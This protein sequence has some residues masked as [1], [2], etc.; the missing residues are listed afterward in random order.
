MTMLAQGLTGLALALSVVL[1]GTSRIRTAA[2]VCAAQA[3]VAAC[4]AA[5]LSHPWLAAIQLVFAAAIAFVASG[6]PPQSARVQPVA[7]GIG[8]A[9]ALLATTLL[10]PGLALGVALLGAVIVAARAPAAWQVLGLAALQNG[11]VLAAMGSGLLI[12][13][14]PL[15]PAVA[16][17][18]LWVAGRYPGILQRWPRAGWIDAIGC[19]LVLLLALTLQWL[20]SP[21]WP[22]LHI[23]AFGAVAIV[24]LAA[25]AT[26][27]ACPTRQSSA[28]APPAGA[29]LLVV[30]G[31]ALAVALQ[32]MP[33]SWLALVVAV[34]AAA[35]AAL[36]HPAEAW[37]LLRLGCL[38][39]G[40]ALLGTAALPEAGPWAPACIIVGLGTLGWLAPELAL[41]AAVL[42]VRQR[43]VASAHAL[44][45]LAGLAAMAIA[46]CGLMLRRDAERLPAWAG[47]GQAGAAVFAW[48]IG[49]PDAH[50]AAILHLVMLA[51]TQS[52][53][54]LA[55][56][57]GLDRIAALA[58]LAGVP[59]FGLFSSLALIV[60][61]TAARSPWLVL[62]LAVGLGML[63]WPI[64]SRLPRLG[65]VSAP[66]SQLDWI[67]LLLLL[68]AGFAMPHPVFAWLRAAAVATP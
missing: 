40:V 28:T 66:R 20:P 13:V 33:L 68:V 61:A 31:A 44:L 12:P 54:L 24:L 2:G 22:M 9:V 37:R 50:V 32:P 65:P 8:A 15:V 46:G 5:V 1:L 39:L 48:G 52:A 25:V 4:M 35:A 43:D 57:G 55:R 56:D 14:L 42:I 45:V 29:R 30:L 60:A 21:P 58:G 53:V 26:A 64:L 47:F 38:G 41:T 27:A 19:I 63:G 17:G 34:I 3:V 59:P 16:A 10:D 11:V 49:T 36:P 7:L 51:L 67:P 62:P 18:G 23:D 6:L